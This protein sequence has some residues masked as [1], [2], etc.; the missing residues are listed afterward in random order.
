MRGGN[1]P[2]INQLVRFGR[3]TSEKK[4]KSPALKANPPKKRGLCKSLYYNT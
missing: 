3:S 4:K 1:M 2:T